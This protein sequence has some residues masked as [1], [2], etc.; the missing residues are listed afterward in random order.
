MDPLFIKSRLR[1]N[2]C[3]SVMFQLYFN[4]SPCHREISGSVEITVN[5]IIVLPNSTN[6]CNLLHG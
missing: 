5:G 2:Q 4:K 1:K 3:V 6:L